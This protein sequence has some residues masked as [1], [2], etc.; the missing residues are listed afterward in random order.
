MQKRQLGTSK[1]EVSALG[2]DCMG[3][4]AVYGPPADKAAMRRLIGTAVERGVTFFDTAEA[5]GPFVNETLVGEALAPF[6]GQV[7]IATKFGFDIDLHTG[8][9]GSGL[10]SRPE[11]IKAV[12]EAALARLGVDACCTIMLASR[13]RAA[14][15]PRHSARCGRTGRMSG[16]GHDAS[17]V[18]TAKACRIQPHQFVQHLLGMFAQARRRRRGQPLHG[19]EIQRDAR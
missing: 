8:Q 5:Y 15:L 1:L 14:A 11:H 6:K 17:V 4:S 7:V 19:G 2:L 18:Q 13:F 12:A 9:R 16:G 3:M 10:N